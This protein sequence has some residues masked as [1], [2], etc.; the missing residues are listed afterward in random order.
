MV[1][2][3]VTR[4]LNIYSLLDHRNQNVLFFL[5]FKFQDYSVR[6]MNCGVWG[7]CLL[8][9]VIELIFRFKNFPK[10]NRVQGGEACKNHFFPY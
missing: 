8:M 1:E 7:R 9:H 10:N 4:T 5:Q 6:E 2:V 3:S